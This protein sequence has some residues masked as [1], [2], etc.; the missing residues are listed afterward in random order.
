MPN[1]DR[2]PEPDHQRR[3]HTVTKPTTETTTTE[4][5]PTNAGTLDAPNPADAVA[6]ATDS[7]RDAP[8]QPN[9]T[10]DTGQP[11]DDQ[12]DAQTGG[13]GSDDVRAARREAATR[14]RE[15]REAEAERDQ[16]RQMA[17]S[18][19]R[20]LIDMMIS[21]DETI[22]YMHRPADLFDVAGVDVA[23]LV[24]ESGSVDRGRLTTALEQLRADR[25][26]LFG[27]RPQPDPLAA[28]MSRQGWTPGGG[29]PDTSAA[30]AGALRG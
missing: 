9:D 14:R 7:G 30:W 25:S 18:L 8:G 16:A 29:Q 2:R 6:D 4:T 11:A 3:E 12:N 13:G 23:D 21:T 22:P 24:D 10:A 27:D 20:Q 15:L 19:Q 28:L 17:G 5:D 1:H 26:Y